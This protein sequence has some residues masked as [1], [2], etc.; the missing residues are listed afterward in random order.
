[1]ISFKVFEGEHHAGCPQSYGDHSSERCDCPFLAAIAE[2]KNRI[3]LEALKIIALT[4][5]RMGDL[6]FDK[7][8]SGIAE[9]CLREIGE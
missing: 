8:S 9:R 7:T 6:S 2:H 4:G 3:M 1:M 5:V